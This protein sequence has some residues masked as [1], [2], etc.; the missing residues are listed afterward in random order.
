MIEEIGP[1]TYASLG[2]T[3]ASTVH[4]NANNGTVQFG[5]KTIYRFEPTLSIYNG[6]Q[7]REEDDIVHLNLALMGLLKKVNPH[8]VLECGGLDFAIG[9]C[10]GTLFQTHNVSNFLWGYNDTMLHCLIQ[11]LKLDAS[12]FI[13]QFGNDSSATWKAPSEMY[14]G[15]GGHLPGESDMESI[16]QYTMWEGMRY[17]PYWNSTYAN[18]I[19][20]T[21]ATGFKPGV[22]NSDRLY[23]FVDSIFR[24][25]FLLYH[26][27]VD[28]HGVT[29]KRFQ[30]P[31]EM[32][33]TGAE[34]PDNVAFYMTEHGFLPTPSTPVQI[35]KARFMGCDMKRI[36]VSINGA[37]PPVVIS[38][39]HETMI[40]VE[41][42]TGQVFHGQ[43]RLQLNLFMEASPKCISLL[44]KVQSTWIPL[45]YAD[46]HGVAS[47]S[48]CDKFKN[49]IYLPL[50]I[51]K[52]GGFGCFGV[53]FILIIV[54]MY[55][56][57][58][59]HVAENLSFHTQSD[60]DESLKSWRPVKN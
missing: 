26:E 46:L 54:I 14:T 33:Q 56:R 6:R 11:M 27:D 30:I 35:S 7:L 57:Y 10:K 15:K 29:L 5:Y 37:N 19:N 8:G 18:M 60:L 24:S 23:L 22:G 28:L 13:Q 25:G 2:E 20:G 4:W 42:M 12:P 47:E 48:T 36:N 34:N 3:L 38:D 9:L 45:V 51:G 40:D 16:F 50:A 55:R 17:L 52:Y 53:S 32:F 49:A 39:F 58:K 44:E 1:Y 43:K 41:P 21:D 59:A 31:D